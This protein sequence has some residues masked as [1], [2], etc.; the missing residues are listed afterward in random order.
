MGLASINSRGVHL[1]IE[2]GDF[3]TPLDLAR[4]VCDLIARDGFVPSAVIEPTCGQG[5][6]IRA[7]IETF[8]NVSCVLG[9]DRNAEYVAQANET[10]RDIRANVAAEAHIADFFAAD[11]SRIVA[12][13]PEPILIIGNPPW[14]TNTT[15]GALGSANTPEKSN[16]DGLRGIEALT[17]KSNFDISEWM[18]R[19]YLRWLSGRDAMIA[20]PCKTAVARKAL[21]HAWS[22][23]TPIL[24]AALY[25][26]D[27]KRH[28]GAA[29]DAC[30]LVVRLRQAGRSTECRE[31]VSLSADQPSAVFGS[32]D[33]HLLSE[34]PRYERWRHLI[35]IGLTGWRSGIKHD[36]ASVFEL[37]PDGG[38]L[39]N[40]L[41]ERVDV[42]SDVLYPLLKS[43]DLAAMRSPRKRL[44][45]P[46]ITT[47]AR[48]EDIQRTAPKA[49]RYL[50]THGARLDGRG[51]SIYRRRPRF[52]IFGVGD[53]SFATWKVAISGLYKNLRF[54]RVQ[55]HEGRAVVFDDTCYFFPCQSE[56]ECNALYDLVTSEPA[57][58][59]WSA[60]I[61][62]DAKRPITCQVLNLLD[63][64]TLA[65]TLG[66]DTRETR[67]LAEH[68]RIPYLETAHQRLLFAGEPSPGGK[69]PTPEPPSTRIAG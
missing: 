28:F 12:S 54:V 35:G 66:L 36:C 44:L 52:S 46:Q 43:S 1:R 7:V 61:F 68:Q 19:E 25:R 27:A 40:G 57:R 13:V 47:S 16:R 23:G 20:V 63:F 49:W 37:D 41:G 14:V 67:T 59:F 8:P 26:L 29:V 2:F 48:P 60:F 15:L 56:A 18:L 17:G 53:Y 9:F 33:G 4:D 31:Y 62:W 32:R 51:S 3:Q 58:E 21:A 34:I 42:E 45:V 69:E 10:I 39:T 55:P 50:S 38:A 6:F 5:A 11:W 30:L 64:A 24:S 22:T 65:R